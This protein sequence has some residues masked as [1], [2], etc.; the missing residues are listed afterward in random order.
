MLFNGLFTARKALFLR[1]REAVD[2][3]KEVRTANRSTGPVSHPS[4]IHNTIPDGRE[5][6]VGTFNEV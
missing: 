6:R 3:M 1:P 2:R 4:P 5:M